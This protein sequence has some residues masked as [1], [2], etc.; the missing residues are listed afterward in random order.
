MNEIRVN[1]TVETIPSYEV[2]EM[3]DKKHKEVL[4]MIHGTSDRDGIIKTLGELQMEPADFFIE[5]TY[6]DV[7]GK[8]R[9]CYECTKMGCDMLANK[10]TGKKGI[11]FTAKYVKAFNDMQQAITQV[12]QLI[13]QQQQPLQIGPRYSYNNYWIKRELNNIKPTDIPD[14]IDGLLERV[15]SYKPNDR[16]TTYEITRSALQELQPTFTEFWIKSM[17]QSYTDKLHKIIEDQRM[18]ISRSKLGQATKTINKLQDTI[19][20]YELDSYDNYYYVDMHGFTV[21]CSYHAVNNQIK[22]TQAY[23]D[24]KD[25]AEVKMQSLPTLKEMG[26]NPYTPK[27]LDIYFFLKNES[28][29]VSNCTKSFLDALQKYYKIEY[30]SFNDKVFADVRVRKY[31]SYSGSFEDGYIVFGIKDLT[32]EEIADLTFEESEC[33]A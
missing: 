11:A 33:G 19:K 21:N 4:T 1:D 3:M 29:D 25:K 7:Q 5:S 8:E 9:L 28:F 26:L 14:Y 32:E 12:G 22:C 30:P 2:A 24:W 17:I 18:Y 15:R 16:L 6:V 23:D 27:K 20:H 10:M 13:E 31:F